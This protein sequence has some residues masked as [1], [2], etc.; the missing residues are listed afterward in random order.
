MTIWVVEDVSK[1]RQE[2]VEAI[3]LELQGEDIS[4]FTNSDIDWPAG[5]TLPRLEP[6]GERDFKSPKWLPD[7]VVLDLLRESDPDSNG[8]PPRSRRG[9]GVVQEEAF[10]GMLF[11][12]RLREEERNSEK[13]GKAYVIVYSQFR[14]LRRTEVFV[15]ERRRRDR[16]FSGLDAKAPALL[17]LKVRQ[18][19]QKVKDGD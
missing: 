14:G 13:K 1:H 3:N 6:P 16:H 8:K 4:I 10:P 17:A 18:C 11:Y 7:I 12:D 5:Q 15:E 9:A 2:A 19:W